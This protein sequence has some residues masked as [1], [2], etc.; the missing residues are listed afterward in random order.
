MINRQWNVFLRIREGG[1]FLAGE[2][3]EEDARKH[4]EENHE[5]DNQG[6]NLIVL[7]QQKRRQAHAD[8][9]VIGSS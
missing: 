1:L 2:I 4:D 3:A 8:L 6:R 9:V 7:L 5:E